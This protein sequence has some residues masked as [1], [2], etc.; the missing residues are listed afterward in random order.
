MIAFTIIYLV[1]DD[2]SVEEVKPPEPAKVVGLDGKPVLEHAPLPEGVVATIKHLQQML[3]DD[4][5]RGFVW[6]AVGWWYDASD[7]SSKFKHR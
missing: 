6:V 1:D 2:V 7:A 3:E 5:I 4:T